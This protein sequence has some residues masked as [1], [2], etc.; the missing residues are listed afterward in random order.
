MTDVASLG[1]RQRVAVVV[2]MLMVVGASD[3]TAAPCGQPVTEPPALEVVTR[4]GPTTLRRVS[5]ERLARGW[6][7]SSRHRVAG[8]VLGMTVWR[9]KGEASMDATTVGDGCLTVTSVQAEITLL[10]EVRIDRRYRPGSCQ[11][12]QIRA[13]ED[14]HVRYN[15]DGF[16]SLQPTARALLADRLTGIGG[17]TLAA[18]TADTMLGKWLAEATDAVGRELERQTS[19]RHGNLDTPASYRRWLSACS[20][21]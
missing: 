16:R 7:S 12:R 2:G 1:A 4:V 19:A 15:R 3:T 21:W 13:H 17:R 8:R 9:L 14:E 11:D 5:S 6:R 10:Q 20:N 18:D